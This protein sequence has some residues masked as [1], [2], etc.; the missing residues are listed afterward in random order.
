M[1]IF[2]R[3]KNP[4]MEPLPSDLAAAIILAIF[5]LLAFIVLGVFFLLTQ[6]RTLEAIRPENRRMRSGQVW[7]QMIPLF[8]LIWQFIVINRI[9]DSIC[10]ALNSPTG[11]SIFAE[12]F[13][14]SNERPTYAIGLA[15][16]I[17]FCVSFLPIYSIRNAASLAGVIFWI[18][19][20]VKLAKY[21]RK[22]LKCAQ[23][24]GS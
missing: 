3:P 10:E 17:C 22:I 1:G 19:Y 9:A 7:L 2:I 18:I 4:I 23:L 13:V 21:K 12:N 11:D 5:L 8:G 14:P 20:W 16:A 6:Y 24:P 15:Y